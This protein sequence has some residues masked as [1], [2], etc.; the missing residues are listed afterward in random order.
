MVK[1]FQASS[2]GDEMKRILLILSALCLLSLLA[3]PDD[4]KAGNLKKS[5]DARGN[6]VNPERLPLEHGWYLDANGG[7]K[8]PCEDAP[9]SVVQSY[10][11]Y[12]CRSFET[13]PIAALQLQAVNA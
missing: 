7:Y 8:G 13:T 9:T 3:W 5:S 6:A 4:L 12:G 2:T 11:G 10:N 1:I